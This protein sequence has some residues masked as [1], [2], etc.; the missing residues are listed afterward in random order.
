MSVSEILPDRPEFD[1]NELPFPVIGIGA[2]AGGLEAFEGFLRAIEPDFR[3]AYVLVQHLDPNHE[4]ILTS[5]LARY[6]DLDVAQITDGTRVTAGTVHVIPAGHALAIEDGVLNLE[7]FEAPRGFRRPIDDFL[8]SLAID[9][10]PNAAGIILSGTGGDG[11]VGIRAIKEAGGVAL[12]QSI[13]Q[14][15]YDGMPSSAINTGLVDFVVPVEEMGATL[16]R[17]FQARGEAGKEV[18]EERDR[19]I[20]DLLEIV[21]KHTG[22]D[23]AHY[24]PSTVL[25]RIQRRMQVCDETEVSDYT[26]RLRE[27]RDEVEALFQD[28][29]INVTSFFR[30]PEAFDKLRTDVIPKIVQSTLRDR[31]IRVWVPGCS[32]GEEAYSIAILFAEALAAHDEPLDVQIFATDIDDEMLGRARAGSYMASVVSRVPPNLLSRYFVASEDGFEV[33]ATIRRMVRFSVHS[34]IKDPPFSRLDLVSCRNLLIYLAP[35][36]QDRV[37]PIFHYAL[38][39]RGWLMLGMSENATAHADLFEP[40]FREDRIYRKIDNPNVRPILG[41]SIAPVPRDPPAMRAA[42]AR[43]NRPAAKR[44]NDPIAERVLA[45]YAPPFVVVGESGAVLQTSQR[46]APYLELS[47]DRRTTILSEL[48]APSLRPVLRALDASLK[49][50]RRRTLRRGARVAF[51]DET[52]LVDVVAD[53]LDDG[54]TLYIFRER[55][56]IALDAEEEIDVDDFRTETHIS[57]LEDELSETRATLRTTVE[58][59]EVSNEE[60]KSSN[61]EMMSMNEELQ[62]GNE[63]LTTANEELN[64]KLRELAE[65]N[66]DLVNF[67]E[68]T[69]IA[70]VFLDT[71]A[72]VRSFT[73]E[74]LKLFR[75]VDADRGRRLVD[76]RS[77]VST[78]VLDEV[79]QKVFEEGEEVVRELRVDRDGAHRAYVLRA[80]P[81]RDLDGRPDGVVLVFEDVSELADARDDINSYARTL[82]S[83]RR[84]IEYL[85]KNAPIGMALVDRDMTYRRINDALASY[86]GVPVQAHIGQRIKEVLPEIGEALEPPLRRVIDSS[87]ALTNFELVA[88][89]PQDPMQIETFE[90][91]LYP[92]PD[93]DDSRTEAVGII[94]RRITDFRRMEAELRNLAGELQH[95]VKN[96]LAT[97]QAIISQTVRTTETR[98][99]LSEALQA[100]VGALA[101]THNLLTHA[102]WRGAQ[103]KDVIFQETAPYRRKGQVETMGPDLMLSPK[104]ALTLTMVLHELATNAAKYGALRDESGN[105]G[106]EWSVR[107]GRFR[108]VWNESVK[109]DPPREPERDSFGFGLRFVERS[110]AH[111]LDGNVAFAWEHDGLVVRL[112]AALDAVETA[113]EKKP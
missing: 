16:K 100:R 107:D 11:T 110:V 2:S 85:Y 72:R 93:E 99:Q 51:G 34:L 90:L 80:L 31:S 28:L 96:T 67:L 44:P 36:M 49:E 83:Q 66:A 45:R 79:L 13:D 89:A 4:S 81:Y 78:D 57:A 104:A 3:A 56:R 60:L 54:T 14:S 18:R 42:V 69:R 91:D 5:I 102:E 32:S 50:R 63:E 55:D 40:A 30:D 70:T 17:Y 46:I 62:S 112:E 111:D 43:A 47:I 64:S 21:R 19:V 65:A 59:L 95:R 71:Q 53:P 109:G 25:R 75:F 103:L 35:E 92:L 38:R 113:L 97:V 22:H 86:N 76:V 48:A 106:V 73:P 29:L 74:A 61:E 77:S 39:P 41:P 82:T 68:S 24:K 98:D 10:G 88:P 33:S 7:E 1:P 12:A 26:E 87:E 6:T 84:E 9:Q 94:V 58:E 20:A 27:D 108:L 52:L 8:Q 105:L 23:F 15:R 37:L 101:S